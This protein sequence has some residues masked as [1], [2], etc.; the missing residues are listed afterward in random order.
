MSL[1]KTLDALPDETRHVMGR[2]L[3]EL[4]HLIG[5]CR[6]SA[7][8]L[9]LEGL[10]DQAA[11]H[12]AR[13]ANFEVQL[14]QLRRPQRNEQEAPVAEKCQLTADPSLLEPAS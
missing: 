4:E 6:S 13:A 5:A 14:G 11:A 10:P 7:L 2:T 8:V 12:M 9:I 3:R 1:T